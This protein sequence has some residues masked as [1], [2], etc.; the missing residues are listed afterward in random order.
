MISR[1]KTAH[2]V[3]KFRPSSV[4]QPLESSYGHP[5]ID[6]EMDSVSINPNAKI[7]VVTPQQNLATKYG[8]AF[9]VLM[10]G[11]CYPLT[12]HLASLAG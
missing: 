12:F 6:T 1:T 2:L 10:P 8:T 9:M 5:Q 4:P 3:A 11:N 7:T